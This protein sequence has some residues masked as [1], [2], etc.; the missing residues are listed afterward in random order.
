MS[1]TKKMISLL[2]ASCIALS[3]FAVQNNQGCEC[4]S[5][6]KKNPNDYKQGYTVQEHQ[7]MGAYN[8]PARIDVNCSW[9]AFLSVSYL[10]W[11]MKEKGLELGIDGSDSH[12]V[13][14]MDFDYKSA[15]KVAAGM[16]LDHDNWA[17][18]L[19]YT[20]V[21]G[22]N[23]Y[24]KTS[25]ADDITP[26]W[27]ISP[28]SSA[29]VAAK[30]YS[31]IDLL[32]F[33]MG[34]AHY[35]GTKL[36]FFPFVGLRGGWIDQKYKIDYLTLAAVAT[37]IKYTSDS[38]LLGPRAGLNTNWLIGEGFRVFG[39]TAAGLYYQDFKVKGRESTTHFQDEP[40]YI[41]PNF[42][43]D[44]GLGWGTYFSNSDWHIDLSASYDFQIF[45]N[46]NEM[47]SLKDLIGVATD[48]SASDLLLQG[49][50]VKLALDF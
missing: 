31:Y 21:H 6:C 50:T 47:R 4:P 1:L 39:N 36:T 46:Q 42:E 23:K 41:T 40:S 11:Q 2:G 33:T 18:M 44:L 29:S 38:W 9:D 16:N 26:T 7:M 10:Y 30:W 34:R 49:L 25:S 12:K 37:D 32:D 13:I 45:W 20:R 28:T 17:L 27:S 3:A 14:N 35:V 24:H 8:A 5:D 43:L 19:E 15:F 22:T 48:G